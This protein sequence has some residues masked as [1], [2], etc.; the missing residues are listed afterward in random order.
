MTIEFDCPSCKA[1]LGVPEK[2]EGGKIECPQCGGSIIVPKA[3][4]NL[5]PLASAG[6]ETAFESVPSKFLFEVVSGFVWV[7]L[8]SLALLIFSFDSTISE[9]KRFTPGDP[10]KAIKTIGI[11]IATLSFIYLVMRF[12]GYWQGAACWKRNWSSLGGIIYNVMML[13]I[14]LL[15]LVPIDI[16]R[17]ITSLAFFRGHY[18]EEAVTLGRFFTKFRK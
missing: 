13:P 18:I 2:G 4:T 6:E 10:L 8:A 9:I 17:V 12:C 11:L 14:L 7:I 3:S 15:L 5:G 16:A 1:K